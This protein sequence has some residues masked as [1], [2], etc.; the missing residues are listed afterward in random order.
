MTASPFHSRHAVGGMALTFGI[1]LLQWIQVM[2][3]QVMWMQVMW[4]QVI[5]TAVTTPAAAFAAD[6][7]RRDAIHGSDF[8]C[9]ELPSG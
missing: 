7:E 5:L 3:I 2:W 8:V 1:T 4:I 9:R 6:A